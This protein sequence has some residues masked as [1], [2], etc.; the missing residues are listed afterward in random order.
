MDEHDVKI[1]PQPTFREALRFWVKLGFISFGG[2]AGQI[3]IMH[4]ELV[5]RK[6]WVEESRFLHALN[7]CM[8]LPGPEAT[9]LAAYCGWM[10]HGMRGA[11]AA[12]ILFILPSVGLLW[13]LGWIYVS[14]GEVPAVVAVF[15]GLKAA[16]LAIVISA[17]L[18]V[19]QRALKTPVAWALATAAF[20]GLYFLHLPFPLI[21]IGAL[22]LGLVGGRLVPG[23]FGVIKSGAMDSPVTQS[24]IDWRHTLRLGL[25]GG[26]VWFAPVLVAGFAVGWN[27]TLTQLGWF[28]S[29]AAVVTFGGAYAVLPYVAQQAV[30]HYH[31]LG[32][33]QMLDGLGLAETTPGPLIMVLQFVGFLAGWQQ[34]GGMAP[35]LAATLGALITTWVTFVPTYLFILMGAPYVERARN[36]VRL[37]AALAAVTASVVGVILNLSVWFGLHVF[38]PTA[39]SVDWFAMVL[40]AG[41]FIALHWA[42]WDLVPVVLISGTMGYC[43]SLMG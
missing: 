7:F 18:R 40:S 36:D 20:V 14:F 1:M 12:G 42:K 39:N 37:S 31:W 9:Q 16:V 25:V 29:K 21:V 43:W 4:N 26:M 23:Q 41:G 33:P 32:A 6:R 8:L 15:H 27:H 35:L 38:M 5:E 30:E 24:N 10:L 3:A 28:F 11:L 13:G 2:P 17:L 34:A 22:T 19:A